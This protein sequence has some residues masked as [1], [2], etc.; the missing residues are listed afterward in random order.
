MNGF[1]K[2]KIKRNILFW[3]YS[4]Q[5]LVLMMLGFGVFYSF[6]LSDTTDWFYMLGI[7]CA[8]IVPMSYIPSY[9]PAVIAFG[10]QRT[11]S[12]FGFQ[13]MNV[14]L[15]IEMAVISILSKFVLGF[16]IQTGEMNLLLYVFAMIGAIGIG[17]FCSIVT[18]KYSQMWGLVT[19]LIIMIVG[20]I[21]FVAT[22]SKGWLDV[23]LEH[24]Y[25]LMIAVILLYL[26]SILG[27]IASMKKYAVK[28]I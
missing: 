23:I 18:M 27:L 14:L 16:F 5:P 2:Q 15:V 17:Q 20:V 13:I 24:K 1:L 6:V 19:F 7:I 12:V 25:I 11:E 22:V 10:A 9:M 4:V 21:A 8:L 3:G 28:S 26:G